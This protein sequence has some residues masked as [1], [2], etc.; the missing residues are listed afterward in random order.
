[1][2][3]DLNA[4]TTGLVSTATQFGMKLLG[5]L[6]LWIAGRTLIGFVLNLTDRA[7]QRQKF[8]A[9]LAGYLRTSLSVIL[10]VALVLGVLGFFGIETSS[11]AALIAAAGVAIGMAWSGLLSNFAAGVFLVLLRPFKTGDFVTAGGVTGT[12]RSI[13][14]FATTIDA[15]DGVQTIVGNGKI[16]SDTIQNY[17]ANAFRRVDLS[18]QLPHGVDP[19]LAVK[20][21]K[22][23]MQRIPHVASSPEPE[24]EILTF[25]PAGPVLAVRPYTSN[26]YYWQVYFETNRMIA[27]SFASAG[28]PVPSQQLMVVNPPAAR[29]ATA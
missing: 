4:V 27:S 22:E 28:F 11:F 6:A 5:A 13:G 1:M 9:T 14:L 24:C 12:V 29:A 23:G 17:S 21:L 15:P 7:L 20:I 2:N 3:I 25:T 26:E 16:F 19:K 10:R 8:D 18:A